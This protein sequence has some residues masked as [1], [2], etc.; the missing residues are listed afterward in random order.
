MDPVQKTISLLQNYSIDDGDPAD[1]IYESFTLLSKGGTILT[2]VHDEVLL[3]VF[4]HTVVQKVFNKYFYE[5]VL[6]F[7][8]LKTRHCVNTILM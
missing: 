4:R 3:T 8:H 5:Q 7:Y 6:M 1:V 2:C